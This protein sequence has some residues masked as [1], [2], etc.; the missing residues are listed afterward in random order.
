MYRT[1]HLYFIVALFCFSE[2]SFASCK[3]KTTKVNTVTEK[4]AQPPAE[5]SSD[6][7]FLDFI[8]QTHLNYMWEGAEKTSGLACERIHLDG[9]YPENDADVV[10]TGGSGFGIAGLIVGIPDIGKASRFK[11]SH[12]GQ[13]RLFDTP[14]EI[15]QGRFLFM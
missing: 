10:T 4:N 11:G 15:V 14:A 8:Q 7:E 9:V 6:D 13:F 3:G 12:L 1:F 5:F 2:F